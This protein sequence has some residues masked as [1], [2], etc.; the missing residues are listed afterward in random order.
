MS[1]IKKLLKF[2]S[3]PWL[4]MFVY[5]I[6][7]L[8]T[9]VCLIKKPVK[10]LIV[11]TLAIKQKIDTAPSKKIKQK[12]NKKTCLD[13]DIYYS[14]G[15]SIN[16]NDE[17]KTIMTAGVICILENGNIIHIIAIGENVDGGMKNTEETIGFLNRHQDE[18]FNDIARTI[19]EAGQ[20]LPSAEP[21]KEKPLRNEVNVPI[22]KKV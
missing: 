9:G 13:E 12:L 18:I 20:K 5:I 11:N 17:G 3:N 21:E 22:K 14:T 4:W 8:T 16:T 10:K 15:Y 6:V 7:I 2:L 19:V 1:R